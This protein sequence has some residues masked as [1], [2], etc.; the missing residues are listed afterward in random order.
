MR[1]LGLKRRR[2]ARK[3][4]DR[5]GEGNAVV[6]ENKNDGDRSFEEE[7]LKGLLLSMLTGRGE[8]GEEQEGVKVAA[9][10]RRDGVL[11]GVKGRVG[12]W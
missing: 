1:G 6:S 12:S 8:R 11:Q 9:E 2:G 7:E 5:G 3:F 10:E 4:G